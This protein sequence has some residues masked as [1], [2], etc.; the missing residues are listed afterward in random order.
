MIKKRI[1]WLNYLDE[2]VKIRFLINS[3]KFLSTND[4]PHFCRLYW[5]SEVTWCTFIGGSFIWPGDEISLWERVS[6][7]GPKVKK[8]LRHEFLK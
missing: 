1:E 4:D 6:Y 2:D 7:F 5:D 8:S 3:M